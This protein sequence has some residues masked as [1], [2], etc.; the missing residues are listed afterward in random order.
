MTSVVILPITICEVE[1]GYSWRVIVLLTTEVLWGRFGERREVEGVMLM[2]RLLKAVHNGCF[3]P[4]ERDWG[5]E[6]REHK[7]RL[8]RGHVLSADANKA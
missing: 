5:R 1:V 4:K 8:I 6:S 7:L 3:G 2:V